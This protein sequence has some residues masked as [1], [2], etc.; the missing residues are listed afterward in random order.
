VTDDEDPGWSLRPVMLLWFVPGLG[1]W[2]RRR[3]LRAAGDGLF[4]IRELF[5]SFCTALILFGVVIL[6]LDLERTDSP[7]P[8]VIAVALAI[9]WVV[10]EV[11][12]RTIRRP[13]D[14]ASE[15]S[16]AE[17]YRVRF[18]LRLA[19]AES[20]A[21]F[22]FVA[23][24]MTGATWLYFFALVFTAVGFAQLAPTRANLR[25]LQE[26]LTSAGCHRSLVAAL[27]RTRRER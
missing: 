17:S 13:L 20:I 8:S 3:R 16:L 9:Y 6:F 27:R 25:R 26:E 11:A 18:F 21:L 5:L 4:A 22:G 24:F 10:T 7:S 19:F 2:M 12:V 23:T 15:Q 14:C 1:L